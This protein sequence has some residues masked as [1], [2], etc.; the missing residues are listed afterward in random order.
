MSIFRIDDSSTLVFCCACIRYKTHNPA[1]LFIF[2]LNLCFCINDSST[3]VLV[4][5]V[6]KK[7]NQQSCRFICLW[8][9]HTLLQLPQSSCAC[10]LV[11]LPSPKLIDIRTLLFNQLINLF[12]QGKSS[13]LPSPSV[14]G[15]LSWADCFC[16]YIICVN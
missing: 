4:V 15:V 2:Y 6:N 14:A 7:E 3:M 12:Q 1:V 8:C 9:F 11:T 13:L 10:W 5:R 16:N